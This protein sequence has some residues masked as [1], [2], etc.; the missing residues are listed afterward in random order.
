MQVW[1]EWSGLES[2]LS[3]QLTYFLVCKTSLFFL[4]LEI[5]GK[6]SWLASPQALY[7]G[8]PFFISEST[9][10]ILLLCYT[11]KLCNIKL[12]ICIFYFLPPPPKEHQIWHLGSLVSRILNGSQVPSEFPSI[13]SSQL[14]KEVH[15]WRQQLY[16]IVTLYKIQS[17]DIDVNIPFERK[18]IWI[19]LITFKGSCSLHS[20]RNTEHVW[21]Q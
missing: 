11:G 3:I 20:E 15:I 9:V 6:G 8:W 2:V 7:W 18:W 5:P 17:L 14:A 13:S 19:W 4:H 1:V 10:E 16:S 12:F 21:K